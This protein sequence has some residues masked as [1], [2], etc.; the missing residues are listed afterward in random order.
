MGDFAGLRDRHTKDRFRK[1]EVTTN[2]TAS[3]QIE[4][5]CLE[6]TANMI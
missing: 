3:L 6:G 2:V 4:Y 1:Q 5:L